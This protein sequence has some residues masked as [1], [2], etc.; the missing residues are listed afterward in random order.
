MG[1]AGMGTF[2][3]LGPE[4]DLGADYMALL[5]FIYAFEIIQKG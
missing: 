1:K 3:E 5:P 4:G 2:L